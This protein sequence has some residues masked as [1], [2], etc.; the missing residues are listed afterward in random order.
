VWTC[1]PDAI[2]DNAVPIALPYFR[3]SWP[4]AIG[5]IAS[6][7]ELERAP[8]LEHLERRSDIVAGADDERRVH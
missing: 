7:A 4:D 5:S 3:T 8:R 6:S 1:A 2:S